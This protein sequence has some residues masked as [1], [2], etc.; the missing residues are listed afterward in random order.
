M[1][2]EDAITLPTML[3]AGTSKEDIPSRLKLYE[4]TRRPRVTRVREESRAIAKVLDYNQLAAEYRHFLSSHD[5]VQH[6]QKALDK[7][8]SSSK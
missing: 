4:D 8:M 5:A 2:I 3:L 1:G 7:H 6:A